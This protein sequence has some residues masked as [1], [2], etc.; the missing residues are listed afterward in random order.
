MIKG[1]ICDLDGA[2]F[3]QG[4]EHF[5]TTLVTKYKAD[6]EVVRTLFYS[7][8]LMADSN[9]VRLQMSNSGQPLS[10]KHT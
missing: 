4:K 2:Y 3:T 1:V 8:D 9:G 6:E 10:R 7:S 5:I